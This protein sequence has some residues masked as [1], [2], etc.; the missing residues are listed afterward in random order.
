MQLCLS[1]GQKCLSASLTFSTPYRCVPLSGLVRLSRSR[2]SRVGF[3]RALVRW[4]QDGFRRQTAVVRGIFDSPCPVGPSRFTERRL[5][6]PGFLTR[7]CP[8]RSRADFGQDACRVKVLHASLAGRTCSVCGKALV[9]RRVLHAP[10]AALLDLGIGSRTHSSRFLTLSFGGFG[11]IS[12]FPG[13]HAGILNLRSYARPALKA[14]PPTAWL[15]VLTVLKSSMAMN[16]ICPRPAK[17]NM[18]P[19]YVSNEYAISTSF[20]SANRLNFYLRQASNKCNDMLKHLNSCG[21][22]L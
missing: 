18:Q 9:A 16:N 15:I 6:C 3:S 13:R 12:F 21:I 7:P 14:A 8:V 20:C 17:A 1:L 11:A 5:S 22:Q 19:T 2:L 10:L 4:G